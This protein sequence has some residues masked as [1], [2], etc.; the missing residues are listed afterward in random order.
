MALGGLDY[1]HRDAPSRQ[2]ARAAARACRLSAR[3][4]IVRAGQQRGC[5]AVWFFRSRDGARQAGAGP[6]SRPGALLASLAGGIEIRALRA[7]DALDVTRLVGLL[8]RHEGFPPPSFTTETYARDILARDAYV[9]GCIARQEGQAVG[10]TLWHPAYDTQSGER[11]AYMVDLYVAPEC[12]K[13]G[14]G[15]AL[16]G[17]A[18]RAATAW[19]GSFLWW[20]AKNANA[21]AMGFYAGVGEM[22]RD[23]AT[24]ACFGDRFQAL[25]RDQ[26]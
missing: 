4:P 23:V 13:Q 22:E 11:G 10:F 20:S 2:A 24:W 19:G 16:M 14:L 12:R 25:L 7:A 15:R 9:S 8:A 26:P 6:G 1:G 3:W 18:A 5:G 17:C 21:L